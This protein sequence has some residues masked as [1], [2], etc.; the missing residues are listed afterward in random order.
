MEFKIPY[1]INIAGAYLDCIE[2]PVVTAT[3]DKYLTFQF[4]E[5]FDD[6]V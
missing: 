5:R 6:E 1:R 2:E 4:K 3:I